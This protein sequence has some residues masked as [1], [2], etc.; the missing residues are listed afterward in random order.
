V[1]ARAPLRNVAGEGSSQ[2]GTD[3]K[4]EGLTHAASDLGNAERLV[5]EHG[6]DLR[7]VPGWG[8]WL[9]W[10]GVRWAIDDL[11]GAMRAAKA[12]AR[13]LLAEATED[14]NAANR[15]LAAS[16]EDDL[17]RAAKSAA[18]QKVRWAIRSQSARSLESM[19]RIASSDGAV[20]VSH[21]QLDADPWL[22][23]CTNGTIDLRTGELRA[24]DRDDLITK[25]APVAYDASAQCPTWEAFLARCMGG[26][27][28]LITYLG[29]IIGY[30]LTGSTREHIL[31]FFYGAGANGKSTF[32]T[33]VQRIM[34]DYASGAARGLLFG[35]RGDRHPTELASLHGKRFVVA[36]EIEA[37]SSFDEALVKD[38]TGGD[39]VTARRMR[40]DFWSFVPT[41]KLF[42]AGNHRPTVRG[43]DLGIWRR[44][45]LVPFTVTI[46][47]N[48][49]DARLPE[50][51]A[52]ELPGILAWAV[53]GALEWQRDGLGD[54]LAVTEATE[55]YRADSD[56]VGDFFA[57]RLT[58][59]PNGRIARKAL[60][61]LYESW[62][63]ENGYDHLVGPKKLAERL[64][65]HGVKEGAIRTPSGPRDGWHGVREASPRE[66]EERF[67]TVGSRD[68]SGA[69]PGLFVPARPREKQTQIGELQVTTPYT[70]AG[71][72]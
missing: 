72:K 29:R 6:A 3:R 42:I 35:S 37:A 30:A 53:R 4:R 10:T 16:P 60:R 5:R 47:A 38:L 28:T 18:E 2:G 69:D 41:H 49:R 58:F 14:A 48:E 43:D 46:P 61:D 67:A 7:F 24:H 33:T 64:R 40:E 56:T 70:A 12:T 15:R 54:P 11:G 22:L 68:V 39:V 44:L 65:S 17:A 71:S 34:G 19:V 9:V 27:A 57:S 45:R 63:G 55:A 26:D 50:K 21:T 13:T 31:V 1:K 23:N 36:P 62:S 59:D 66:R 20:V 51:L 32:L 8:V 52:A 25:L